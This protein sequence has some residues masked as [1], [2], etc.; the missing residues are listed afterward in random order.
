MVIMVLSVKKKQL[1]LLGLLAI[2]LMSNIVLN[3][4]SMIQPLPKE[5]V[6]GSILD[7]LI[8]IP[9]LCYFIFLHKK[10]SL[11]YILPI[12]V[13]SYFL[14]S[15][16]ISNQYL[17]QF[18]FMKWFT[19]GAEGLFILVELSIFFRVAK[20]VPQ[21]VAAWKVIRPAEPYF[22]IAFQ[23]TCHKVLGQ[24]KMM[25]L[26]SM[27]LSMFYY[28]LFSWRNKQDFDSQRHFTYHLQ[29]SYI[30]FVIMMIHA[31]VIE[32][33]GFHFLLHQWNPSLAWVLFILNFY[34]VFFF[35]GDIQAVRLCPIRLDEKNMLLQI[36][37]KKRIEIDY[38]L[39]E[40]IRPYQYQKLTK[41]EKK[42]V[43]QA[44]LTE[45][46]P[47]EPQFELVLKEK[48]QASFAFGIKKSFSTVYI[49]LDDPQSFAQKLT[50]KL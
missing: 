47:V 21:L 45:F 31:M 39:I 17:H 1:F 30:A 13:V 44:T 12:I 23:R 24:N 28:G 7:F 38:S 15:F 4:F 2:V 8:T 6:L 18:S 9:L 16:I 35:L 36:G 14:G 11:K 43:F 50:E 19:F 41:K 27:D 34:G 3:Q 29:T 25:E 26:L 22:L 48:V 37:L 40:E 5:V 49:R 33:I 42:Q 32:T 46:F 20:K 10:Y